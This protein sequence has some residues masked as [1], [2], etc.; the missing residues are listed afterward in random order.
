M[1]SHQTNHSQTTLF[2][3][4][5]GLGFELI[6]IS[7][8]RINEISPVRHFEKFGRNIEHIFSDSMTQIRKQNHAGCTLTCS[9]RL[10]LSV[11]GY[12]GNSQREVTVPGEAAR[13]TKHVT[14]SYIRILSPWSRPARDISERQM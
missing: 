2:K 8:P 12:S 5:S 14:P 10:D 4:K 6:A 9:F 3:R 7:L 11:T 1:F 13:S